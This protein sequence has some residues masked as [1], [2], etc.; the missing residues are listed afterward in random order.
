MHAVAT[1]RGPAVRALVFALF[2][3]VG[4]AGCT[5]VGR[6]LTGVSLTDREISTCLQDCASQAVAAVQTEVQTHQ[7]QVDACLS[8]SESD[9][10][11]CLDTE[12]ARHAA[13][14]QAIADARR[15]CQNNCHRQGHGSA[16]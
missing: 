13:A 4:A 7:Q 10:S 2:G 5:M 1:W 16:G 15:E 12:A 9:K 14:M 8:L 3:I 11:A 6:S